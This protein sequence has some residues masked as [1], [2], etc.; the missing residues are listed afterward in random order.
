LRNATRK[1]KEDFTSQKKIAFIDLI[2]E[3]KVDI[4]QDGNYEDA[5]ID[6]REIKWMEVIKEMK[7]LK[8]LKR[9]CFTRNTFADIPNMNKK[10][11]EI[12]EYCQNNSIKFQRLI[13]PARF[14]SINKQVE[15]TKF[16]LND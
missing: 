9:V 11:M 1:E 8:N 2:E 12:Q 16:L 14:Y 7:N 6:K 4:G 5:Y 3:V 13:S 15:W 10:V